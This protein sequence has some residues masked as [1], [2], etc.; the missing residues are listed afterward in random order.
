MQKVRD[1]LKQA[2]VILKENSQ[3][4]TYALDADILLAHILNCER[5][6]LFLLHEHSV[7]NT[8]AQKYMELIERR[9]NDEPIAYIVG[10]KEFWGMD[11]QVNDSTL[12]P[13][14]DTETIIESVLQHFQDANSNYNILDLGT[15]SGCLII[16]LAKL[17]PNSTYTAV[18]LN[19]KALKTAQKNATN[20]LN[21]N[22][23]NFI[24]SN[25]F[26]K[27]KNKK[28]DIIVANPPYID[29]NT[30][31]D[32]TV[33]YYEPHKA[34]FAEN[35]GLA[36]YQTIAL[37]MKDFLSGKGLAFFEIGIDQAP[38]VADIFT[39]NGFRVIEIRNDLSNIPR[40]LVVGNIF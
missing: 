13:R 3:S 27:L 10:H 28:Y 26:E 24:E 9:K 33:Q 18:D 23:I 22:N 7:T 6:D 40:V 19:I 17:F 35:N 32:K 25:W 37:Q 16:T 2:R 38:L 31:L 34:L 20:L 4:Q 14:P 11:F 12:I 39:K 15:G 21:N 30:T 29:P 36:D 1:L 8:L 5:K